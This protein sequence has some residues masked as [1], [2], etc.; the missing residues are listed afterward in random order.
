MP[1]VYVIT[2]IGWL[3]FFVRVLFRVAFA[4]QA[5][6]NNILKDLILIFSKEIFRRFRISN[7]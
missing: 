3:N 5:F 1:Y 7:S 6:E 4:V 2:V